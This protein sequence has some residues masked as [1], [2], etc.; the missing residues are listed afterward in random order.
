MLARR[1]AIE[2]AIDTDFGYRSRHETAMMEIL[3]VVQGIDYLA[4]NLRRFMRPTGRHIAL[5]MQFGSNRVAYQPLG[6]AGIISPWNY[7]VSQ[8]ERVGVRKWPGRDLPCTGSR[9]GSASLIFAS[10]RATY[11]P[12]GTQE[13]SCGAC[14]RWRPCRPHTS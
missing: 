7:P 1:S 2:A 4:R 6:V 3:G 9:R 5:D 10:N 11:H 14:S 12:A 8:P 13:G